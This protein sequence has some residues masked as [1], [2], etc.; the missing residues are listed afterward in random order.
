MSNIVYFD[1]PKPYNYDVLVEVQ[2]PEEKKLKS[3]TIDLSVAYELERHNKRL[4]MS[5]EEGIVIET[6]PLV[7]LHPEKEFDEPPIKAGDVVVFL[8]NAGTIRK[9]KDG[10]KLYRILGLRDIRGQIGYV[11][12]YKEEK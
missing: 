4:D 9:S 2:I 3:S 6:G 12:N 7:G 10:K 8:K 11:E 5:M 1:R